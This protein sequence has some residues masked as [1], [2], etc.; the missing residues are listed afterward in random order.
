MFVFLFTPFD[1]DHLRLLHPPF[2][3]A[4]HWAVIR[5]AYDWLLGWI[6][7]QGLICVDVEL[8]HDRHFLFL[9][10]FYDYRIDG[11][12]PLNVLFVLNLWSFDTVWLLE[13]FGMEVFRW[14]IARARLWPWLLDR[15][16]FLRFPV[17]ALFLRFLVLALLPSMLVHLFPAVDS[18]KLLLNTLQVPFP[19][20]V[21]F[22][23]WCTKPDSSTGIAGGRTGII[24]TP[25]WHL[26]SI[27]AQAWTLHCLLI[28][29]PASLVHPRI[30]FLTITWGEKNFFA[31]RLVLFSAA[32]A[33]I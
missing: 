17:L 2:Y 25:F 21:R 1:P 28:G 13:G 4:M 18:P 9:K 6:L 15:A 14:E 19:L 32:A 29:W 26:I 24:V 31:C 11:F 33:A 16:L 5:C 12:P 8:S 27:Q 20:L 30:L 22:P 3:R 10:H 7:N 23:I